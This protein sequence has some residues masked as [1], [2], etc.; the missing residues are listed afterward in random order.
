MFGGFTARPNFG[1]QLFPSRTLGQFGGGTSPIAA[2]FLAAAGITDG[3]IINA[4]NQLVAD[5]TFYGLISKLIAVY[6]F[7]GGT[8]TTHKFNLMNPADTNAAFRINFV[9][10]WTHSSNGILGNGTNSYANTFFINSLFTPSNSSFGVYSRTNNFGDRTIMG[11]DDASFVG[12]AFLPKAADSNTYFSSADFIL[13]G[14]ANYISDTR[15]L[16]S[17]NR[18]L[19]TEKIIYRNGVNIRTVVSSTAAYTGFNMYIG[20]RNN[21]NNAIQFDNRQIAFAYMSEGFT[22]T[23]AANFYTAVQAFQTTLGRNV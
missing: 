14:V 1:N 7:V 17:L 13:N 22:P 8:A 10:G 4:I 21:Q 12:H 3:T 18:V 23:Q 20:A 5:L 6:P 11:S 15:G 16:F 19:N 9:G 2:N